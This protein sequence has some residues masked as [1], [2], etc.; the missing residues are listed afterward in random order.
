ME[1][2]FDFHIDQKHSLVSCFIHISI[3]CNAAIYECNNEPSPF[4]L[5]LKPLKTALDHTDQYG[6]GCMSL[7]TQYVPQVN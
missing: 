1:D 3:K 5:R 7:G 2:V 4:I 6:Y